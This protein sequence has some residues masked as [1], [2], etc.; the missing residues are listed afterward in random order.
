MKLD[1]SVPNIFCLIVHCCL[2]LAVHLNHWSL[3]IILTGAPGSESSRTTSI[4]I[5]SLNFNR[6]PGGSAAQAGLRPTGKVLPVKPGLFH[7][8]SLLVLPTMWG[9]N[10]LHFIDEKSERDSEG[11]S[12]LLKA[13]ESINSQ[14]SRAHAST[15]STG[16]N[17]CRCVGSVLRSPVLG[18]QCCCCHLEILHNFW[19]GHVFSFHWPHRSSSQSCCV[20]H[21]TVL[22]QLLNP[23]WGIGSG[24]L[25]R[26]SQL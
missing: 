19:T 18:S 26:G 5:F 15:V 20:A 6:L 12:A 13:A 17:P 10:G 8:S 25:Q 3:L 2:T 21:C 11:S 16:A 1:V 14:G 23:C 24:S 9:R 4:C 7:P 22:L